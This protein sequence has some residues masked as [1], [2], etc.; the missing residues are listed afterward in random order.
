MRAAPGRRD[1]GLGDPCFVRIQRLVSQIRYGRD[2]ALR[3][4]CGSTLADDIR[5]LRRPPDINIRYRLR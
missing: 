3:A 2:E 5:T 4:A 1:S